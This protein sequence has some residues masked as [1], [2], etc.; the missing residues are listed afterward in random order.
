M[1]TFEEL[2]YKW[3][4][5]QNMEICAVI[6]LGKWQIGKWEKHWE[7][8]I[9]KG[10]RMLS[11]SLY[12]FWHALLHI[13]CIILSRIHCLSPH[14]QQLPQQSVATETLAK[15]WCLSASLSWSPLFWTHVL[16]LGGGVGSGTRFWTRGTLPL[17][18]Q[19]FYFLFSDRT[20]LSCQGWP[21]TCTLPASTSWVNGLGY[22]L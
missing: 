16:F 12:T 18:R 19:L 5:I 6:T 11:D 14:S 1:F 15:C 21:Q 3:W 2:L 9:E 4:Y 8:G 20:S 22:K 13:T 10:E 7:S 17:Y